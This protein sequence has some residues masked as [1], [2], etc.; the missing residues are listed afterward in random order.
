MHS[1]NLSF[2][3]FRLANMLRL[4][5]FKNSKGEDAHLVRDG[6]DWT[7]A[8]WFQAFIGEVGEMAAVRIDYELDK[9][10]VNSFQE[11]MSAE[12]ADVFTYGDL[13]AAR[14]FDNVVFEGD[15]GADPTFLLME[16]MAN[17]G[18]YANLRKKFERG[19]IDSGQLQ[20]EGGKY[21]SKGIG[22][23]QQVQAFMVY[24][25][26]QNTRRVSPFGVDLDTAIQETFNNVSNRVKCD[27]HFRAGNVYEGKYERFPG[28]EHDS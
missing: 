18:Q 22:K 7:P 27:V 10:D 14:C 23:L 28:D 1:L 12:V 4:P 16:A 17:I 19:D 3:R 5:K 13:F 9:I 2:V 8:A 21:L 24:P 6:S 15:R 25:R 26:S 20:S 11:Y